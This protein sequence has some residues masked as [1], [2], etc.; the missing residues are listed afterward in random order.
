VLVPVFGVAESPVAFTVTVPV[1]V[2]PV[3]VTVAGGVK[4]PD[5]P[6]AEDAVAG[7]PAVDWRA[8]WRRWMFKP[9]IHAATA[10]LFVVTEY[11]VVPPERVTFWAVVQ[12][13]SVTEFGVA[14]TA[15]QA[16]APSP[17]K[18]TVTVCDVCP[19]V[20]VKLAED[21]GAAELAKR[22]TVN[23]LPEWDKLMELLLVD[24]T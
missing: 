19:S 23:V 4:I 10:V 1:A 11:G 2:P 16:P 24:P 21:G 20:I 14:C 22:L 5:G 7:T 18:F 15:G 9:S 17:V 12:F 6:G 8:M 3:M 13:V